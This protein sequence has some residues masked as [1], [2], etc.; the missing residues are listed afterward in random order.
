MACRGLLQHIAG[1]RAYPNDLSGVA[2]LTRITTGEMTSWAGPKGLVI[3]Q[4]TTPRHQSGSQQRQR[5][6]PCS[7]EVVA[8]GVFGA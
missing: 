1:V 7:S 6:N 2:W 3:S 8:P 4:L 5:W